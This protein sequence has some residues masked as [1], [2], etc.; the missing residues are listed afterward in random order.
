MRHVPRQQSLYCSH[1]IYQSTS[2]FQQLF[3]FF[4]M[5]LYGFDAL[6]VPPYLSLLSYQVINTTSNH[7]GSNSTDIYIIFNT[8]RFS[9][10]Y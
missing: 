9:A 3:C 6:K 7:P 8:Y 10:K 5:F 1:M 2:S 4:R